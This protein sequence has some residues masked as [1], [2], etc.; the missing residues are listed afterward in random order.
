MAW[1]FEVLLCL[2]QSKDEIPVLLI[3]SRQTSQHMS[4]F[5]GR[6]AAVLPILDHLPLTLYDV[7]DCGDTNGFVTHSTLLST[8]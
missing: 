7:R 2:R 6:K 8:V 1:C 4:G 3:Q 5:S